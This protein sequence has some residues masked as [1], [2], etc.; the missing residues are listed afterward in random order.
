MLNKCGDP[1][2]RTLSKQGEK[3]LGQCGIE[4][5][6]ETLAEQRSEKAS[7]RICPQICPH[8]GHS[9]PSQVKNRAAP[10]S[11]PASVW[12]AGSQTPPG[13]GHGFSTRLS[14]RHIV[15]RFRGQSE[16]L[17]QAGGLSPRGLHHTDGGM[18]ADASPAGRHRHSLVAY[19]RLGIGS[20]R[21]GR[22]EQ[23]ECPQVGSGKYSRS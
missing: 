3:H 6:A 2:L 14:A 7:L 13:I 15:P 5:Q 18:R 21:Q 8:T 23:L 16:L 12:V 17:E 4:K 11:M 10:I 19:L 20:G 9:A 1:G 22:A